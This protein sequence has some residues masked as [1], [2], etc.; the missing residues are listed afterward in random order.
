MR[1]PDPTAMPISAA[2]RAGASLTPSPVMPTTWPL[3]CK[4]RTMY[5]LCLSCA[6]H[7]DCRQHRNEINK[8]KYQ[9]GEGR[10]DQGGIDKEGLGIEGRRK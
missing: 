6:I 7:I 3:C 1:L 2:F 8:C 10:R 4:A 5:S 9:K